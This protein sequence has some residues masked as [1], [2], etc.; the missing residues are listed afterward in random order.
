[1]YNGCPPVIVIYLRGSDVAIRLI[2]K[3]LSI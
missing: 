3:K 1:M 2:E